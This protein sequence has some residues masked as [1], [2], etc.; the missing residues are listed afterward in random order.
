MTSSGVFAALCT[1]PTALGSLSLI[2]LLDDFSALFV[3]KLVTAIG[4]EKLDLLVPELLPVTV[5]FAFALRAGHPKNFRHDSR[6]P[7]FY[8]A[9]TLSAQR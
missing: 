2:T 7:I 3:Q 9:K 6:P 8:R 4:A 5:K 1:L